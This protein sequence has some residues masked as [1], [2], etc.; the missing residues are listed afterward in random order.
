MVDG[1]T[2][3]TGSVALVTGATGF[4]GSVLVKQLCACGIQVRAISRKSSRKGDLQNLP[5]EWIEGNVCDHA[6]IERAVAGVH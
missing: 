4:T 6:T 1:L 2:F 3:P 5:I